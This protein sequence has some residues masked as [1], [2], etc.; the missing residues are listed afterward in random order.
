MAWQFTPYV[1]PVVAAAVLCGGVALYA[2]RYRPLPGVAFLA[3][4][5]FIIALWSL[6]YTLEL[7][8]VDL[9]AKLFWAKLGALGGLAAPTAGLLFAL[10]YS[11]CGHWVTRRRLLTLGVLP[12]IT[13]FLLFTNEWHHAIWTDV[14]LATVRSLVILQF[15]P[16]QWAWAYF[17]YAYGVAAASTLLLIWMLLRVSPLYRFQALTLLVGVLAPWAGNLLYYTG[18]NLLPGVDFT[19]LGFAVSGLVLAVGFFRFRLFDVVPIARHA[20]LENMREAVLA[21][22]D[23]QRVIDLNRAAQN[24]FRLSPPEV[25]GRPVT[26]FLP[27]LADHGYSTTQLDLALGDGS[28]RRDFNLRLSPLT[29]TRGRTFGQLLVLR[30]VTERKRAEAELRRRDVILEALARSG[31]LL[32]RP[33]SLADSLDGMLKLL[34]EA[35][36]V[37]RAA[38]FQNHLAEDGR[39]LTDRLAEWTAPGLHFE[40][41]PLRDFDYQASGFTRWVAHLSAGRPITGPVGDFPESEQ[42]VLAQLAVGSLA[43]VPIFCQGQWWGI[44]DFMDQDADRQWSAAEIEAL[45]SAAGMLGAAIARQITEAAEREQNRYLTLLN[46]ITRAT[47]E[48]PDLHTLLQT[49]ADHLR[50]LFN[51]DHCFITL[52]DEARQLPIPTVASGPFRERYASVTPQPGE[53]TLS[54]SVLRAERALV[55][56]DAYHSS[57]ISPAI[58]ERFD[59]R[60]ALG[61]PLIAQGQKLGVVF[62][63]FR[64]PHVFSPNDVTRGEQATQ[65]VAL[66]VAQARLFHAIAVEHSHFQALI[67]SSHDGIILVGLDRRILVVNAPALTYL[68][69]PGRPEEWTGQLLRAGLRQLRSRSPQ[70]VRA[71]LEEFHRIVTGDEPPGEG[72][73]FLPPR[74]LRWLNLPVRAGPTVV[75]RLLVVRDVTQQ[76]QL[77]AL[78]D[79]LTHMMVH[80]LRSPLSTVSTALEFLDSDVSGQLQSEQQQTLSIARESVRFTLDLVNAILDVHQLEAGQIVLER[81]PIPLTHLVAEALRLQAPAA[82]ARGLTIL[83]DVPEAL[84]PA[85]ADPNLIGRV[86]QNLIHNAIKFTPAGGQIHIVA[87]V[88]SSERP[89]LILTVRDTGP[90]IPLH[91]QSRLFQKFVSERPAQGGRRGSGLGLAFCKLVVEAHGGRIWAE[92]RPGRGAQFIFTLPVVPPPE[93]ADP[94]GEAE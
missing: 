93:E 24:L 53:T 38:V 1:L 88:E 33:G 4:M 75:G 57:F 14:R 23:Q 18:Q 73:L 12:A 81:L 20:I 34:G 19:P 45:K 40:S 59:T 13:G 7:S 58:A 71:L 84:P 36:R 26:Q 49:L 79:E 25:M 6:A 67:E 17:I 48:T 86:L 37:S 90:G 27:P 55:V 68:Q 46:T 77:S 50:E 8:S 28:A 82:A 72:D 2:W 39:L 47:V 3:G 16:G 76:R 10:H 29:D 87:M 78:R 74:A 94:P 70:V 51:A 44:L 80:D 22:D 31:E 56:D 21:V 41:S 63:A 85:W 9:P 42:A 64:Q 43:A 15:T 83:S 62:I 66:A 60:S 35:A 54:G 91:V 69:L 32:L 92:S 5:M 11:G 30:D 89:H 61:L 52:W 65:Q